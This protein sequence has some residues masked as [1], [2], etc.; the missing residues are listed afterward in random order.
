[1]TIFMYVMA[2]VLGIL[3]SYL[4][5]RFIAS[6]IRAIPQKIRRKKVVYESVKVQKTVEKQKKEPKQF[7][8]KARKDDHPIIFRKLWL[9]VEPAPFKTFV[10][11]ERNYEAVLVMHGPFN[12]VV[13]RLLLLW[14][15][16][17]HR[18][19]KLDTL[20]GISNESLEKIY[21]SSLNDAKQVAS[22]IYGKKQ[23]P[24]VAAACSCFCVPQP[25]AKAP[26]VLREVVQAVATQKQEPVPPAPPATQAQPHVIEAAK[27]AEPII[28]GFKAQFVGTVVSA[29]MQ[30]HITTRSGSPEEYETYTL[31]LNTPSGPERITGN[32]L[33]RAIADAKVQA[34]DNIRV[35]YLKD[36]ELPNTGFKKKQYQIIKLHSAA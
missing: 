6:A 26:P 11:A 33:R 29:G 19:V 31:T 32:D 18:C 20:H 8:I 16:A 34:G 22:A 1:M 13:T 5:I 36:V 3:L 9:D 21:T 4:M 14:K 25:T 24:Q 30:K 2:A 28:K 12:G 23:K 35:I 17:K 27:I 10:F 7:R 15:A